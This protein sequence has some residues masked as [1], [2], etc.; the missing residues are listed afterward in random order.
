MFLAP[1]KRFVDLAVVFLATEAHVC[2]RMG[3]GDLS[4]NK[5]SALPKSSYVNT[6]VSFYSVWWD[7]AITEIRHKLVEFVGFQISHHDFVA[8]DDDFFASV[9]NMRS[10]QRWSA[11][12]RRHGAVSHYGT[13]DKKRSSVF[14]VSSLKCI[15]RD[16]VSFGLNP[17]SH[18]ETKRIKELLHKTKSCTFRFIMLNIKI[19][20]SNKRDIF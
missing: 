12:P 8:L 3:L 5:T 18:A 2:A 19:I 4:W 10:L 13:C 20:F 11:F 16:V 17:R 15:V 9:R 7:L 1:N 14:V 6:V